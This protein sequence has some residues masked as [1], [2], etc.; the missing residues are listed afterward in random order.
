MQQN[1]H[2]DVPFEGK[3]SRT[4]LISIQCPSGPREWN[5]LP[6]SIRQSPTVS[7]VI[8][9]RSLKTRLLSASD[10]SLFSLYLS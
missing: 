4:D 1:I 3:S 9:S 6:L 8:S 2:I 7:S 5:N 10:A